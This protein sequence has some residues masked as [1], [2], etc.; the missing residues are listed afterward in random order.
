MAWA[1]GSMMRLLGEFVSHFRLIRQHFP[2]AR[3]LLH[4]FEMGHAICELRQRQFELRRPPEA[5]KEVSVSR[6][7]VVEKIREPGKPVVGD[8]E[9][10][11]QELG[12]EAAN[13]ILAARRVA[14]FGR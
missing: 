9:A 3:P 4:A 13:G 6:G 1:I 8:L 10:F 2:H 11:E 5:P 12:R 7:E 14:V